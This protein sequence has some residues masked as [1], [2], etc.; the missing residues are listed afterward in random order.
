[1]STKRLQ[2]RTHL[3]YKE[4]SRTCYCCIH[5]HSQEQSWRVRS[6]PKEIGY[7][8]GWYHFTTALLDGVGSE[9]ARLFSSITFFGIAKRNSNSSIKQPDVLSVMTRSQTSQ[10]QIVVTF[11]EVSILLPAIT[12]HFPF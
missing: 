10:T 7:H 12:F 6:Y 1:M 4:D 8:K 3:V 2:K 5:S 9:W 11:V